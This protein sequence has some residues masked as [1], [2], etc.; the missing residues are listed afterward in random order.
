MGAGESLD[1]ALSKGIMERHNCL[2]ATVVVGRAGTL[3]MMDDHKL[4]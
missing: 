4:F 1:L 3:P 2:G